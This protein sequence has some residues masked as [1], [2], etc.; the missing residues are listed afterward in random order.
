MPTGEK[1]VAGQ[2]C[3]LNCASRL[4]TAGSLCSSVGSRCSGEVTAESGA[5][6]WEAPIKMAMM[7]DRMA[8]MMHCMSLCHLPKLIVCHYSVP[9][10]QPAL[11]G[12]AG[13]H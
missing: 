4:G 9:S 6:M 3:C 5:Y 11:D 13:N 7:M 10:T 2:L 12:L 1:L 8:V